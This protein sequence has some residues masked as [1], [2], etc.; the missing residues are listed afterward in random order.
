MTT[1]PAGPWV[2]YVGPFGYPEGGA[3]ARRVYGMAESLAASGLNVV[4]ASGAGNAVQQESALIRQAEGISYCLLAERT[5]EHWPKPLRRLRY[6]W[7]GDRTLAWLGSHEVLPVAVVLYSGYTP[8]LARLAPWCRRNGV[9]LLFDA[10]EWYEPRHRWQYLTSPYQWNIEWAMR[11]LVPKLDAVVA[12][13]TY[14]GGYYARRGLPVAVVP[15]TTSD[16]R[17]G[18]WEAGDVL[19][20]CYAGTPGHKDDLATIL[21]AVAELVS[22]GRRIELTVA[23]PAPEAVVA[24]L[25]GRTRRDLAWLQL[26]GLLDRHE[27]SRLVGR[28]DF[29]ILVRTPRRT[30]QAGF[31][32]KFVESLA[33]GTPVIANLTSDLALHLRDGVTGVVAEAPDLGS[34]KAALVRASSMDADALRRMREACLVHAWAVFH[35]HA[36]ARVLRDLVH[37]AT[38]G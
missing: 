30:S 15:P 24:M 2:A 20:L 31:P 25:G 19:R 5:A 17:A 26:Q 3:A 29:S 11:R 18:N 32:T 22:E 1:A 6:A 27:V 38:E 10:V 16:I 8:F 34:V 33:A 13:S 9:R 23:G 21:R 28:S 7:M 35:P 14:L 4:I 36:Y 37:P 12:I